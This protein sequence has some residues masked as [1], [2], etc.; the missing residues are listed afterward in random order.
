MTTT[1]STRLNTTDR[2]TLRNFA[3]LADTVRAAR[4]ALDAAER[5]LTAAEP[6]ALEILQD[7]GPQVVDGRSF[8]IGEALKVSATASDPELAQFA[9]DNGLKVTPPKPE[10]LA[11]A[12]LRSAALKGLDVSAV[13]EVIRTPI[14]VLS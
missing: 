7:K 10:T 8:S 9:R 13:A 5:A 11:S 14:V 6:G 2:A 1:K 3:E 4:A 12:T